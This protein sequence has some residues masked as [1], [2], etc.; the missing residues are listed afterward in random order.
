MRCVQ[1]ICRISVPGASSLEHTP[2]N[3]LRDKKVVP[4]SDPPSTKDV[5]HLYQFFDQ[6]LMSDILRYVLR[7]CIY[8]SQI[9]DFLTKLFGIACI[10]FCS[11]KL[12]VLTGAGISTE[13]GIPDYRRL[14]SINNIISIHAS[15]IC[16]Y[17]LLTRIFITI[18]PCDAAHLH[19]LSFSNK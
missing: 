1:T 10:L 6:R 18:T 15:H 13:C 8:S 7:F 12:V 9:A 3:F 14:I 4:N 5:D 11:T 2:S 16:N 17:A 19:S